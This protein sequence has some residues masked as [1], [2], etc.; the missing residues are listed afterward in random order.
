MTFQFNLTGN[1]RRVA[2]AAP[3]PRRPARRY[4]VRIN[5]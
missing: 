1:G 3:T 4:T 5:A 2:A